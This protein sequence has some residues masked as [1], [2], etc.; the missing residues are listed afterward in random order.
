MIKY[1][2]IIGLPAR[3]GQNE[4]TYSEYWNDYKELFNDVKDEENTDISSLWL[5]KD[6]ASLIFLHGDDFVKDGV[7]AGE[8]LIVLDEISDLLPSEKTGG[9]Q[10]DLLT[11]EIKKE[12]GRA[13]MKLRSVEEKMLK[14]DAV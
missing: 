10:A 9:I 4:V 2:D 7:P 11:D 12:S 14:E 3:N 1:R 8:M 6:I 5:Y 13:R